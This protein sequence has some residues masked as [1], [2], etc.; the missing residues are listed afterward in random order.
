MS[1]V[2]ECLSTREMNFD[3]DRRKSA[4]SDGSMSRAFIW[5]NVLL[6]CKNRLTKKDLNSKVGKS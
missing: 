2:G 6:D 5:V 1:S 3:V 4:S